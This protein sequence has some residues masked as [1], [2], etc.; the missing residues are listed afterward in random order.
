MSSG[1]PF[2]DI[3]NDPTYWPLTYRMFKDGRF[4]Y[5][6]KMF[7]NLDT[8]FGSD[9]YKIDDTWVHH[10]HALPEHLKLTKDTAMDKYRENDGSVLFPGRGRADIMYVPTKYTDAFAEAAALHGKYN[11]FLEVAVIKIIDMIFRGSN[12]TVHELPICQ[13]TSEKTSGTYIFFRGCIDDQRSYGFI[14]PFKLGKNTY[15]N[16]STAYDMAQSS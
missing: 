2:I 14:H 5:R 3:H 4:Y 10:T 9:V 1:T 16:W 13:S 15:V 7:P 6:K 8:F 11:V 12:Y